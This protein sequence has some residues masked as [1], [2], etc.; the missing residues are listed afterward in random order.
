MVLAVDIE[1]WCEF[2]CKHD[3]KKPGTSLTKNIIQ[4]YSALG[5][6]ELSLSVVMQA[7]IRVLVVTSEFES[8][9]CLMR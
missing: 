6:V 9:Y 7:Q 1:G 2:Y 4:F 5:Q 8:N 3:V